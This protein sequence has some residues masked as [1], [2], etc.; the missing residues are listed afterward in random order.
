M[1]CS[2]L[3]TLAMSNARIPLAIARGNLKC[4]HCLALNEGSGAA[5]PAATGGFCS[6]SLD[7]TRICISA[8]TQ[9]AMRSPPDLGVSSGLPN[10][11]PAKLLA[12][13]RH[14]RFGD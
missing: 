13:M 6:S 8:I 7:I 3:N 12:L 14:G 5:A 11:R 4:F 9:Q 10:A 2:V 1:R